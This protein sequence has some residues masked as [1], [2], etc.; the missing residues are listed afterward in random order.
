MSIRIDGEDVFDD[1]VE[2]EM[3]VGLALSDLNTR[4]RLIH[5]EFFFPSAPRPAE[6]GLS[7]E[8]RHLAVSFHSAQIFA[9][10]DSWPS[11]GLPRR[12]TRLGI[13]G[14]ATAAA[15]EATVGMTI[16]NLLARFESLGHSCDFGL[17]QRE[18]GIEPL[19]LLRVTG[20]STMQAYVGLLERFS[21]IG[22]RANIRPYVPENQNEY[23]IHE[24]RYGMFYHTFIPP[25]Q[26]APEQLIAREMQRLPFL[27]R[28][29]IEDLENGEKIF[30]LRRPDPMTA[31]EA[32]AIWAALNLY[33][34]NVLL[35]LESGDSVLA[36]RVEEVGPRLLKGYLD[37]TLGDV[38]PNVASWLC[39]CANTYLACRDHL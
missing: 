36:G 15:V 10:R 31:S 22:E 7:Q 37:G 12:H 29:F 35:Y 24:V 16:A 2:R 4:K 5:I 20:I 30:L 1:V 26:S 21:N 13:E 17:V 3:A 32:L 19:G 18:I 34:D 11:G 27:R 33:H 9:C 28:K 39:L 6:L 38:A 8:T 23:W 25:S 14:P